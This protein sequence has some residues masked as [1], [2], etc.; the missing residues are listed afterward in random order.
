MFRKVVLMK[1]TNQSPNTRRNPGIWLFCLFAL[2]LACLMAACGSEE[3]NPGGDTSGEVG[4]VIVEVTNDDGSVVTNDDGSAVTVIETTTT[5]VTDPVATDSAS[6]DPIITLAPETTA[7]TPNETTGNSGG[8]ITPGTETETLPYDPENHPGDSKAYEGVMI[9][10]VY[11]TGKKGAEAL[12]SHGYVQLYNSSKKDISLKGAALYY[13]TEGANPFDQFLF[14]DDA[15][16]PAEGYYLVRANAPADFVESNAVL[17]IEQYDAEWDIY[18]DNKEVRLLL[19]PAGWTIARDEDI[20][21]FDDSISRFV[22]TMSYHSSVYSVYDLSRNKIAVR[23][24]KTDYSGYH[25]VNLTRASTPTLEELCTRTSKGEVNTVVG[26]RITEVLFSHNAGIYEKT[27]SLQLT[28]PAGYTVYYTTDGSDPTTSTTRKKY[29]SAI[30]LTDTSAMAWGPVTQAWAN[31]G[32]SPA[33]SKQIGGHVIKAC[34]IKGTEKTAVFTNTYFITDDL[35]Q[36]GVSIISISMPKDEVIDSRYDGFYS[37]YCPPGTPITATRPRGLG[38]M[39]VFDA[40][41]NRVGNSRVEMA[42]SGNGSS[43]AGMK[44]LRIYY[45]GINNQDAGLFSDLNYDIFNGLARDAEGEAITSFS[46][47]LLRN[48][49]NDCGSSYIRDAYMQRVCA[50]LNVDTMASATTLVF[51]NGEFWGVYNLRERYSGEYV[52][53]HYGVDKDNVTILEND[54]LALT[55]GGDP[56]APYI[57]SSG[58]EGDEV[59]F[60]ELVNYM[61]TTNLADAESYAYVCSQMDIDSFID[62]W[63]ARLYFNARDWPENNMKVWRNKNPDDPSGMDTKWHFTLLDMD[64]GF[65]FYPSGHWAN[66]SEGADFFGSFYN[67]GTVCGDMMMSLLNNEEFKTRLYSRYYDLAKNYFTTEYLSAV[68]EDY[69]AERTP[70]ITL[71]EN[72]WPG[73]YGGDKVSD[74]N[75]NCAN[76]RSFVAKRNDYFLRYFLNRFG[77]TEDQLENMTGQRVTVSY[78]TNRVEVT[79]NGK[80]VE[81]GAVCEFEKGETLTLAVKATVKKGYILNGITFTDRSGKTQTID[82]AEGTFKITEAGTLAILTKRDPAAAE[83]LSEGT[84]VAG[85]SYLFYLTADGELYAWG[86]NRMGVLG[87]GISDATVKTPTFVMDGVAKVATS[88]GNDFENGSTT[89]ATAILTKDGRV[90]TVGANSAGQLGRN[91]TT[92][93]TK[94]R[95]IEFNKGKIVDISMGH[96]HLLVLDENGSLWGV[97]S[98]SNG[99][100]GAANAGSGSTT[101]FVKIADGVADMSAG[102][103]ST[104]YV[105]DDGR[106]W[107]LGDNRWNKMSTTL[108]DTI[109]TPVVMAT[110]IEFIDSGEHQILAVDENG[111]LYY[112][113]WRTVQGFN[114]GGGNNPAVATVMNSGVVKADIY[115]GNMVILTESGDAYV[116]GLNTEN[117]IGSEA[118]TNGTPKKFQSGVTD[119]AAGYGFTAYLMEDGRILIQGNNTYGQ[120]GNGTLGGTV[121]LIEVEI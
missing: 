69:I 36:Y 30:S 88:S 48:S 65:S 2:L 116:Y 107:G 106:L 24:A 83:E 117:G 108:G 9:D 100:L 102:R 112:A 70:L 40:N 92:N 19:A 63:V 1:C 120:A 104:V 26:S 56:N 80:A 38:I 10:S 118:V 28:G 15:V 73:D 46:R 114:Q 32:Y 44:S 53:S 16:I 7:P 47:L 105:T 42:V 29:S 49:G 85:A 76:M 55:S 66:T 39:E 87:L 4:T 11:G 84:L 72:R 81:N 67:R 37:G 43:G 61:R 14:P 62:L 33:A 96:D 12:I 25:L 99:A 5:E 6:G 54:Y 45:K 75:T 109:T 103:R 91:G 57:V 34:A 58:V 121:N 64:M 27:I 60:N 20:T 35:E 101:A 13:K 94:L 119:V 89:F 21:A 115:H 86:D 18:I 68:L 95:E 71:Q 3:T 17:N 74:W 82:G 79:V 41:G 98:N 93:D 51:I 50:G 23:T 31:M 59:P 111:K 22:A 110:N 8:V 78:N 90:L 52:E 113:G 97:G 77:L